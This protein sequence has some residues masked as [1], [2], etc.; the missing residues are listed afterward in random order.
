MIEILDEYELNFIDY[1][2]KLKLTNKK[3]KLSILHN[4]QSVGSDDDNVGFA[5][6]LPE[7]NT[8][9][10]PTEKPEELE[11][12]KDFIIHNLA[13]EYKHFLQDCNGE[14]FDEAKADKF[15][16]DIVEKFKKEEN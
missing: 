7:L 11:D 10:L 6:Y 1:I 13:H 5:V 3:V 9:M 8:I 12:D 4:Y 2:N 14:E 16:D 15:A